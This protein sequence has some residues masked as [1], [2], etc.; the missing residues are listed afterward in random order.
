MEEQLY[1]RLLKDIK[2]EHL[3][4]ND[5]V[6]IRYINCIE[7]IHVDWEK[8][9]GL[10]IIPQI[11]S[12]QILKPLR[13]SLDYDDFLVFSMDSLGL[14]IDLSDDNKIHIGKKV[15]KEINS[16]YYGEEFASENM[17]GYKIIDEDLNYK[18][19]NFVKTF[20]YD[21]KKFVIY[22]KSYLRVFE[23]CEENEL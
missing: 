17:I 10:D 4:K 16:D 7:Q 15:S 14:I 5:L 13:V 1:I 22:E 21:D 2:D 3:K 11:D 8:R 9:S 18:K 20:E 6:E 19:E 23:V 12:Y